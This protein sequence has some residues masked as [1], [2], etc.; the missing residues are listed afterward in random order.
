MG[1]IFNNIMNNFKKAVN[2]NL[3]MN[4]NIKN[5]SS[6]FKAKFNN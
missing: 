6:T 2:F 1:I 5:M 3:K 4:K